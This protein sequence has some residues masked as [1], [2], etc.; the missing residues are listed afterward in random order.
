METELQAAIQA[1]VMAIGAAE[2]PQVDSPAGESETT[3]LEFIPV[4]EDLDS[5][6]YNQTDESAS[7]SSDWALTPRAQYAEAVEEQWDEY[8]NQVLEV[9]PLVDAELVS[10]VI[11][12]QDGM[13]LDIEDSLVQIAVVDYAGRTL[14]AD[15]QLSV[16]VQQFLNQLKEKIQIPDPQ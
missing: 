6:D 2:I 10:A 13:Y 5:A 14:M 16:T 4:Y 7:L 15:V 8:Q 9:D 3:L 1:A 11:E 12:T